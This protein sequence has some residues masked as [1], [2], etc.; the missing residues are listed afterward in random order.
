M[1][2]KLVKKI[3]PF[4]FLWNDLSTIFFKTKNDLRENVL[5]LLPPKRLKTTLKIPFRT[6]RKK[7]V[8]VTFLSGVT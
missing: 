3:Q 2:K 4:L 5:K 1:R 6:N 8:S 7:N